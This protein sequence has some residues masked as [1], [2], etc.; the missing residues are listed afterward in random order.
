MNEQQLSDYLLRHEKAKVLTQRG[1]EQFNEGNLE[2][3]LLVF[4]EAQD[5]MPKCYS[6]FTIRYTLS[7]FIT[8]A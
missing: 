2:E 6:Q 5:I 7:I 8:S 3:A 1:I 4:E